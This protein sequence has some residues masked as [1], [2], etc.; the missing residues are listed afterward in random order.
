MWNECK[1]K[2]Y[3]DNKTLFTLFFQYMY[4][5]KPIFYD[6]PCR[7]HDL[8]DV[9]ELSDSEQNAALVSSAVNKS[10]LFF[11]VFNLFNSVLFLFR[12]Q[13]FG[14]FFSSYL[15]FFFNFILLYL[16]ILLSFKVILFITFYR[17]L[18]I[19]FV[20]TLYLRRT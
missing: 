20:F 5:S 19:L 6:T 10:L 11:S 14:F 9:I 4:I 1:L 2:R 3:I 17:L 12:S 18:K 16:I 8:N 13:V 7:L 15:I